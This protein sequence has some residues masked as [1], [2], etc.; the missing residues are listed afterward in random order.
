M[1]DCGYSK[2][3]KSQLV[4]SKRYVKLAMSIIPKG[5]LSKNKKMTANIRTSAK[6][7]EIILPTNLSKN[8]EK[9]MIFLCYNAA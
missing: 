5:A 8:D 3:M 2:L 1:G 7:I 6:R 4:K 9:V